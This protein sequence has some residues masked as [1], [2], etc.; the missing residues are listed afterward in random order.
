MRALGEEHLV[1][2]RAAGELLDRPDI[3][4]LLVQGHEQERESLVP[5]GAGLGAGDHEHPLREMGVGR[6]HLL[7]VDHPLAVLD[8]SLG[9]HVGEVGAGVRLGVALRPELLDG[10]D[11]RQEAGLLLLGAERDQGGAEQ[12]LA[13]VV[14][15]GGRIG[16]RVLLVEDHLLP[17]AQPAAAVLLR[18]ADA[19]PA[20][21]GQ[22]P[23]PLEPVLEPLVVAA[24]TAQTAQ[25]RPAAGQVLLQ[26]ATDLGAKGLV[27]GRVAQVH[28]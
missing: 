14:D 2:L 17:Q 19:G 12:L 23:V 15:P 3:H 9:L 7:A 13:Q 10:D 28:R 27:L 4:A 16:A 8:T 6:P 5:L 11:L 1:E 21:L 26:P 22:Q 24:S 18:P 25:L 20:V